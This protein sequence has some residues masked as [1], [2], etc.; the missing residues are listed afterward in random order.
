MTTPTRMPTTPQ[1]MEAMAP[2]LTTFSAYWVFS[3]SIPPPPENTPSM[4][5]MASTNPARI[6]QA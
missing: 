2:Y 5:K 1:N 4:A 6:T 3:T